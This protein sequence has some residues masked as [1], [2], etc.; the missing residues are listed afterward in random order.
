MVFICCKLY[1]VVLQFWDKMVTREFM[2]R[3]G[4][5]P[6][7]VSEADFD[8]AFPAD[9]HDS[10]ASMRECPDDCAGCI[11]DGGECRHC[12]Q[13]IP[14]DCDCPSPDE[15]RAERAERRAEERADLVLCDDMCGEA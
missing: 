5:M 11:C 3:D 10:C 2:S 6:D 1:K 7:N 9:C 13:H 4:R 8:R 12:E 15:I 14:G